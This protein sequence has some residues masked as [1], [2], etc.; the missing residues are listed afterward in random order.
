[1]RP[2][3]QNRLLPRHDFPVAKHLGLQASSRIDGRKEWG[4]LQR[5]LL[6][7]LFGFKF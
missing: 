1:M 4:C 5:T 3:T 2:I 6:G 7:A